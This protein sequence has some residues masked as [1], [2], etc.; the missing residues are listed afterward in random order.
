MQAGRSLHWNSV[1]GKRFTVA[2]IAPETLTRLLKY[3]GQLPDSDALA[4]RH[5]DRLHF[6]ATMDA[7]HGRVAFAGKIYA[8]QV[9]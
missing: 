7:E 1:F 9:S 2:Q 4:R 8:L 6:V 3:S 5:S